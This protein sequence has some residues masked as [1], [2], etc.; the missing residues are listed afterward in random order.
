MKAD[1]IIGYFF[2]ITFPLFNGSSQTHDC[3]DGKK[4]IFDRNAIG[5]YTPTWSNFN[6]NDALHF[7][8]PIILCLMSTDALIGMTCDDQNV[9]S[10][11]D[12]ALSAAMAAFYPICGCDLFVKSANCNDEQAKRI[13]LR[14]DVRFW[15]SLY[16]SKWADV[17]AT[18][19]NRQHEVA[20]WPSSQLGVVIN[21]TETWHYNPT[22]SQRIRYYGLSGCG[23]ESPERCP[24]SN[25]PKNRCY[26]MQTILMHELG[27]LLG[28]QHQD[29]NP[30]R[31]TENMSIMN[32]GYNGTRRTLTNYDKCSVRLLYCRDA[33]PILDVKN[34]TPGIYGV[35]EVYPFP[36]R[37]RIMISNR[38]SSPITAISF[39]ST[40][41]KRVLQLES[42]SGS[43]A[44]LV[45]ISKLPSGVFWIV[46]A[47]QQENYINKILISK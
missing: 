17:H 40:D 32:S 22:I 31:N 28:I 45:D 6:P 14:S 47:T 26:D 44:V 7:Q 3:D 20:G 9:R 27:H 13:Q 5:S 29:D 8:I 1:R 30:D 21:T 43:S 41:G 35:I 10:D 38:S 11:M 37:D 4:Y 2:A 15:S 46:T 19:I 23:S 42:L 39:Y 33:G 16:P 18:A 12:A 24:G 34:P 36:A 25:D